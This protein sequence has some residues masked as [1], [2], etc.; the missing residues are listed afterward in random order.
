VSPTPDADPGGGHADGPSPPGADGSPPGGDEAPATGRAAL[1]RALDVRRHALQALAIGLAVGVGVPVLFVV[2]LAGG[3]PTQPLPYYLGLAFVVFVT[4]AMLSVGVL[5]GRRVLTLAV[6]PAS[7]VRRSA[8]GGLLAGL[9]WLAGGAALVA[10]LSFRVTATLL[11][12]GA[13]LTLFGLWAVHTRFKRTSSL[14]PLAAVA[15]WVGVAGALIVADVVA[16]D[17]AQL[18]PGLGV[19]VDPS[20]ARLLLAGAGLLAASQA[21]GALLALAGG[22]GTRMGLALGGVPLAGLAVYGLLGAGR[23]ALAAL[24]LGF[25]VSWVLVSWWLRGVADDEVPTAPD[26][27]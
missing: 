15:A 11:V 5:T 4:V 25:G 14:R 3:S 1:L 19:G 6:T 23:P 18:L 26:G 24:A 10:G 7:I 21:V 22:A 2:V 20:T 8:T 27:L 9:L 12:P 17:M 13:I 16:V